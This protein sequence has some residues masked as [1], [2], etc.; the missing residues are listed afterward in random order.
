MLRHFLMSAVLAV[1]ACVPADAWAQQA[2][3]PTSRELSR[4]GLERLWWS[5]ATVDVRRDHVRHM[6]LDEDNLYVQS[7]GGTITAFDAETGRKRWAAQLGRQ[8]A[9]SYAATSNERL[10][11][12]IT[13]I[14]MYALDKFSGDMEWE[15][16]LPNQPSTSVTMDQSQVYYGT[17]DGSVYS[18]DLKTI[19]ELHLENRL[20]Q[21]S[22]AA[23]KWRYKTAGEVTTPPLSAGGILNFASRDKSLYSV[24]ALDRHLQ[25]Q[26]E[27]NKRVSAPLGFFADQEDRNGN[28][29]LDPGEDLNGNEVL[30]NA[31]FLLL[32]TEDFNV[33]CINQQ[34][35][36][37]RWQFVAGLP[38][39]VQPRVVGQDVYAFPDRGGMYCLNRVTGRQRWWRPGIKD[40]VGATRSLVFVSD[41]VGSLVI[42]SR[43]D[44]A[45]IGSLPYRDLSVRVGNE[46]SDRLY[47][48]TH[49]GL[50]VTLRESGT[51]FPTYHKFPERQPLVPEFDS[52]LDEPEAA[53]TT[54]DTSAP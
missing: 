30:D 23:M 2:T 4:F 14:T 9:P 43:V 39:R 42:L 5:Q 12:V 51:E 34:T 6:V 54:T 19:R 13:G 45:L 29:Q 16:Q 1:L 15:L 52:G 28:N 21:F 32:A 26:F 48:S 38:L 11:L 47:L 20:P 10:V 8:D 40:Y 36:T 44:G 46:L 53:D 33:F 37:I 22:N 50:V 17:L 25:W 24:V 27:T 35:G 31:G 18:Y 3:L 41:G 49:T 7:S